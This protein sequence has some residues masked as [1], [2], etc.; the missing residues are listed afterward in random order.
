[1]NE[2]GFSKNS[3]SSQ[4]E[5]IK[6]NA[7]Y[8]KAIAV[9]LDG[10]NRRLYAWRT[11]LIFAFATFGVFVFGLI[12][13]IPIP[14]WMSAA[15]LSMTLVISL[16]G[17]Y[18][19][20]S[21]R[22]NYQPRSIE[23]ML[24]ILW[25]CSI[26]I[27]FMTSGLGLIL[28]IAIFTLTTSLAVQ[29]LPI[30]LVNLFILFSAGV[31]GIIYLAELLIPYQRDV[32]SPA[33]LDVLPWV[34]AA[35]LLIFVVF[36]VHRFDQFPLLTKIVVPFVVVV[37]TSVGVMGFVNYLAIRETLSAAMD[38]RLHA[39]A[40][41]TA[42]KV[43]SYFGNIQTIIQTESILPTFVDYLSLS[44]QDR[45]DSP[46]SAKARQLLKDFQNLNQVLSYSILDTQGGVLLSTLAPDLESLR[47]IPNT[48][49]IDQADRNFLLMAMTSR[50]G[51]ASPVIYS[52]KDQPTIYY[53]K[54]ILNKNGAV[55]GVLVAQYNLRQLQLGIFEP[56][57]GLAGKNSYPMLVTDIGLM[58]ASGLNTTALDTL[59][60]SYN[61][62]DMQRMIE[63]NRLPQRSIYELASNMEGFAD[64]IA[65]LDQLTSTTG[66][67]NGTKSTGSL[68]S[69]SFQI[70]E[71]TAQSQLR[72]VAVPLRSLKGWKVVF[73]QPQGV[74]LG[75]INDSLRLTSLIVLAVIGLSVVGGSL[76]SRAIARPMLQLAEAAERIQVG[77]LDVRIKVKGE[78]EIG[79]LSDVFNQMTDQLRQM[80]AGLE[81]RVSQRTYELAAANQ[82]M[83]TRTRQLETISEVSRAI[84]TER[85]LEHLLPLITKTIS[86]QF[87]FYHVGIFLVDEKNEFAVLR[88]SNSDG[89]QKMLA[90]G[91]R[92]MVGQ[93]G[94]VGFV[95]RHGVPRVALDVGKDAI[96]FNNPDLPETRSELALPL[97]TGDKIIGALDVQ[98]KS[99]AAFG[100]ED[101]AL[102]STLAEQVSIAIENATLFLFSDKAL[103]DL[104]A[105]QRQYIQ[106]NWLGRL[107]RQ[108]NLGYV[109]EHGHLKP[110]KQVDNSEPVA[111]KNNQMS[112]P[113]HLRGAIIGSIDIS[114]DEHN[115]RNI[116]WSDEELRL[117]QSIADQV[118]LALENARLLEE[119]QQRAE[120]ESMVAQITTK[121]RASNDPQLI[122]Q[123]AAQ[124]IK[125]ALNVHTTHIVLPLQH[126][127]IDHKTINGDISP[128]QAPPDDQSETSNKGKVEG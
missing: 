24:V 88:A 116:G 109:Y 102:L 12:D 125:R 35:V 52:S 90:R 64:H 10:Q 62:S 19:A 50:D 84:A 111:Q 120:R 82:Q 9:T 28:A 100:N 32:A 27:V 118:G 65:E 101:V 30:R 20:F 114:K 96:F 92:L 105:A 5:G 128:D 45:A 58:L 68:P 37:V 76:I 75:Q 70:E 48:L 95:T 107:E 6:I 69:V 74:L 49:G 8:T 67:N 85:N 72:G 39:A 80:V 26:F 99:P 78:D 23:L 81:A 34:V 40:L 93:Q 79:F 44:E 71:P 119:T 106:Q 56:D 63:Q 77:D 46:D 112:L 97:K 91:H 113:I 51:Y 127:R 17:F 59:I 42:G 121:L 22:N 2:P 36:I 61:A 117:A 94:I 104:Q 7:G 25:I 29:A 14:N 1:M 110:V 54:G 108:L 18:A 53:G 124:E 89:G 16:A 57:F 115:G 66:V 11:L 55:S 60:T 41:Q 38:D 122:L 4:D 126:K 83:A 13:A 43:D 73:I 86:D 3:I 33:I 123:T 47:A 103:S 31:A 87:G 15:T 98:S 21:N